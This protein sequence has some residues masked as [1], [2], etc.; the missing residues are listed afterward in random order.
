M[1]CDRLSA[2]RAASRE[3][4]VLL[5]KHHDYATDT[6]AQYSFCMFGTPESRSKLTNPMTGGGSRMAAIVVACAI[7]NSM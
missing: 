6:Y 4:P 5:V 7:A 2:L 1:T 3:V